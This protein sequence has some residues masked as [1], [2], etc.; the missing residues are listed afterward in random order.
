M[1]DNSSSRDVSKA[2]RR[3]SK[4]AISMPMFAGSLVAVA[5][6]GFVIGT[7]TESAALSELISQ[8]QGPSELDLSSVQSAYDVLRNKYDG[9]LDTE[10]LI[11]G[12]KRGLVEATGDPYTTYFSDEEAKAFFDDLEGQFSGIGAELAKRDNKLFIVSTIDGSPALEAGLRANDVIVGVDGEDASAW[13][14][15]KAVSEIRGEKGTAVKLT[16]LRDQEVKEFSIV[17]DTITNPSVTSEITEDNIGVLRISRFGESETYTLARQAA[18]NFKDKQVKGVVVDLRGNGG[19]YLNAAQQVS[20]LWLDNKVVVTERRDGKVVDTL[21]SGRGAILE[22]V[23]TVVLVDGGS[24]S[25]SEILAG[26]LK[27]NDAATL[28]GEK[29]FGKGSVQTVEQ[30]SSGGQLKVTIAK[31]YTPNGRNISQQGIEPDKKVS[32]SA[33]DLSAGDDPQKDAALEIIRSRNN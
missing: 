4:K 15:E 5:L 31:W 14:I 11:E 1:D 28:V 12:A 26:A 32:V 30:L 3:N 23:P 33:D 16:I 19:G 20:G 21:K 8:K 18:E 22:G 27:D 25:A 6:T 29:T 7:R 2:S 17:R 9:Q 10:K 24:A 13:S